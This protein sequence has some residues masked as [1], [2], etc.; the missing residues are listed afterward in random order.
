[1]YKYLY[2]TIEELLITV[3]LLALAAAQL[4][5][6]YGPRGRAAV[7]IG[8]AAGIALSG[9]ITWCRN[10]IEWNRWMNRWMNV[11]Q[12]DVYFSYAVL[13]SSLLF[14]ACLALHRVLGR[15]AVGRA[16]HLTA[17]GLLAASLNL[18]EMPGIIANPLNFDTMGNGVL[19][20]EFFLRLGGWLLAL[21]V[22]TLYAVWL[23]RCAMRLRHAWL[24]TAALVI[25][26]VGNDVRM[27]GLILRFWTAGAKWLGWPVKYRKADYPWA[28]PL[29]RFAS[30]GIFFFS[31]LAAVPAALIPA[32]VFLEHLRVTEPY[33]NRAQLRRHRFNNRKIRR[34][35][36]RAVACFAVFVVS[37]TAVKA[38]ATRKIELSPPEPYTVTEDSI[39]VDLEQVSDGHL[40]RFEYTTANKISVRW[41]VVKKPN[42]GAYGVGLDACDVCGNAGYY[43]RGSQVVCKRCD[44]VMNIN[45]IG[46]KGGCNPI[47]LAYTIEDGRMVFRLEDI[48]A[49]EAEFKF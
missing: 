1:M 16:A 41:I 48:I 45:T 9:A 31:M 40:H 11:N 49:G 2:L 4:A 39:L 15:S 17:G 38:Y 43:E 30:S 36:L 27:F 8:A 5:R 47:P 3:T 7:A 19:S 18:Y 46:F 22:L 42:G 25:G 12:Q 14:L 6:L 21:L 35:A 26:L 34:M 20:G 33:D 37:L 13:A 29:S 44:V 28:F 10:V 32:A 23:Y 24:L